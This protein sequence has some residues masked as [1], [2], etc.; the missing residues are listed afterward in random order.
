[1]RA[2]I[3]LSLT[4][5]LVGCGTAS[6]EADELDPAEKVVVSKDDATSRISPDED[7]SIVWLAEGNNAYVGE[8][9]IKAG[10]EVPD[11]DH[12]SE[13]YLYVKQGGGVLTLDG[14][15]HDLSEGTAVLIPEGAEHSFVN[16]DEMTV[17]LQVFSSPDGAQRYL[18]WEEGELAEPEPVQERERRRPGDQQDDGERRRDT[19]EDDDGER[20]RQR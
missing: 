14:E 17:A 3:A 9:R 5:L 15:D 8:L 16:G 12:E 18:D 11:H 20:R 10:A 7:V 2:V 6:P 4:V 13:E 19:Q 1:M